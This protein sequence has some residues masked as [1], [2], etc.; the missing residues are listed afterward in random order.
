MTRVGAHRLSVNILR[1]FSYSGVLFRSSLWSP[2]FRQS[3]DK[4]CDPLRGLIRR[5]VLSVDKQLILA[6]VPVDP[7]IVFDVGLDGFCQDTPFF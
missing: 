7:L 3:G 1:R 2:L 5:L 6:L 4:R